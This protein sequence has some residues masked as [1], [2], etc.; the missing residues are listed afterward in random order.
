MQVLALSLIPMTYQHLVS[1]YNIATLSSKL[2]M[3]ITRFISY[4]VHTHCIGDIV[5]WN[6][7][8][9]MRK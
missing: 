1:P 4:S 6:G 2:V 5:L 8:T 7:T 9:Y 3:R